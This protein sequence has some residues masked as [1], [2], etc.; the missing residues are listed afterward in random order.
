MLVSKCLVLRLCSMLI[1]LDSPAELRD[2]DVADIQE[3]EMGEFSRNVDQ[4]WFPYHNK[5]VSLSYNVWLLC[6]LMCLTDVLARYNR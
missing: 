4:D 5:T 6:F 1:D 2:L 3:Q